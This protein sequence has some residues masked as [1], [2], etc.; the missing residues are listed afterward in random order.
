MTIKSL[1]V[2]AELKE[3]LSRAVANNPAEGLILSG[4]L[5]SSI[6][7]SFL[8]HT[9]CFTVKFENYGPDLEYARKVAAYFSL[10]HFF[11]VIREEEA[12]QTIPQL[13]KI[14]GSFDLA[15][16]N[17]LAVYFALKLAKEKGVK[18]VLTGDGADELFAGY[19]YMEELD[20]NTYLPELARRM[21]FS[22][23]L[24]GK[25]LGID[26]RQPFL[27]EELVNFALTIKPE[28]KIKEVKGKKWGKWILRQSF[29]DDLPAEIIWREKTPLE[30]G[31]GTYHLREIISARITD[32]EFKEKQKSYPVK[33]INKEHVYYYEIFRKVV[34]EIPKAKA[35]NSAC[36][37]CGAGMNKEAWHCRVCGRST[38][39]PQRSNIRS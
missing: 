11:K 29:E 36:P 22:S 33:F 2:A 38:I 32:E 27:D 18:S 5:D 24:L 7:A 20:L 16:P 8:D 13:I 34:G 15:L 26:V 14:L 25:S 17:D 35:H 21:R 19:S 39:I 30:Y 31:S 12:L 10:P 1:E 4:G 23:P 3:K 37:F 9:K 6:L 28:D